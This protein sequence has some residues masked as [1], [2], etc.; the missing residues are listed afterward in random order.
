MIDRD[1]VIKGLEYCTTLKTLLDMAPAVDAEPVKRGKW[2]TC[3]YG[4]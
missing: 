2:L 4:D 1:K 3:E